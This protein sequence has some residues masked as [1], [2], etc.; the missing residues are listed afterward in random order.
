M[1]KVSNFDQQVQDFAANVVNVVTALSPLALILI[2]LGIAGA[3]CYLE[4]LFQVSIFGDFALLPAI[5]VGGFRFASGMG[6]VSLMKTGRYIVGILFALVSL[7]LTYYTASHI[8]LIAESIAP[9]AAQQ[10][11]MTFRLIVWGGLIG[12]A[13]I[14]AYMATTATPTPP[15]DDERP[16]WVPEPAE[17]EIEQGLR[18]FRQ[19][20]EDDREKDIQEALKEATEG[21]EKKPPARDWLDLMKKTPTLGNESSPSPNGQHTANG[22]PFHQ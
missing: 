15:A 3:N 6:G 13:L 1:T 16:A 19:L 12:E 5:L 14:A 4:Y 18:E 20:M 21:I 10:A 11:G 8:P 9:N 17:N 22:H 2:C 7:G